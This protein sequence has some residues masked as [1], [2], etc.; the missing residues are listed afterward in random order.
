MTDAPVLVD[1]SQNIAD[2]PAPGGGT[3]SGAT[4]ASLTLTGVQEADGGI[5]TCEVSNACGAAV[6]N[7]A[8]VGTPIPPDFDRDGDVDEEDF[9]AFNA[10]AQG[11]AVPFPPG[12]EDKD[13]DGDGDLDA[14]DFARI[15]RCFAGPGV[16][17]P[18]GCA[19]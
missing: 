11:P 3:I 13:L 7:G 16:L 18:A 8:L 5:Y 12:C 17:P 1:S 19:Q 4:T 9:E 14:D 6:S 10:C 15:Q 2:G